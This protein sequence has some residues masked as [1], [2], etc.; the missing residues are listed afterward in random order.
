MKKTTMV[1]SLLLIAFTLQ[2]CGKTNK[3]DTKRNGGLTSP[4]GTSTPLNFPGVTA[5][6][7]TF[8]TQ[9]LSRYNCQS[10]TRMPEMVFNT[11]GSFN[12]N[13]AK[14]QG[15]FQPGAMGGSV[16]GVYAGVSSFGDIMVVTKVTN[17]M[18]VIGFNVSL[19]MCPFHPLII[20]GRQIGNFQAPLGISLIDVNA[21]AAGGAAASLTR[22]EAAQ[23]QYYPAAVIETT[24]SAPSCM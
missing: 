14:V 13:I 16:A 19:M 21:C 9:L 17:G 23:Y 24:F 12:G 15:T 6:Q 7:N 20:P 5:Q 11:Q 8:V 18:S 4:T 2:S 1:M 3:V 22:L 10:G